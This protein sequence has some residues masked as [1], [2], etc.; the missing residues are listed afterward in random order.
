MTTTLLQRLSIALAVLRGQTSGGLGK[1]TTCDQLVTESGSPATHQGTWEL[2]LMDGEAN[3]TGYY[4][5]GEGGG[6]GR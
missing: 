3:C 6:V 1:P 4:R 5:K 2:N